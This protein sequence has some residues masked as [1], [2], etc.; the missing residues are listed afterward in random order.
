MT[1]QQAHRQVRHRLALLQH[2]EEAAGNVAISSGGVQ[3]L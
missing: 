3:S 1:R 2:L